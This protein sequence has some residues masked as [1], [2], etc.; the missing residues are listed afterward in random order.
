MLC[1][2]ACASTS[3][4]TTRQLTAIRQDDPVDA[5]FLGWPLIGPGANGAAGT[6]KA[7]GP[8]GW[9]IG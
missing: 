7:G 3:V 9:I 1:S 4:S 5:I 8:G 2:A 6:G